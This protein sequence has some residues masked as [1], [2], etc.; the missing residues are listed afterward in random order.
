MKLFIRE[1]LLLIFVQVLQFSVIGGLFW[2]SGF[3]NISLVFYSIFLGLFFLVCYLVYKYISRRH[4]YHRLSTKLVSLDESHQEIENSPVSIALTDLLKS[5][6]YL[7]ENKIMELENKQ[8]EHL[9]FMDR[10]IHQ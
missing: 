1:H 9:I 2:L 10:W 5:Q 8:A 6:Y 3:R 4:F 7:Y